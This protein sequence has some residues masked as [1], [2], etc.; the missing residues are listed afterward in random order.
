MIIENKGGNSDHSVTKR[1][2][3][4]EPPEGIFDIPNIIDT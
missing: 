2:K 4:L 1:V 3:Y